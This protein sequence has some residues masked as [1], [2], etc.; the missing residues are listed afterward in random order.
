MGTVS[1]KPWRGRSACCMAG[2]KH[3]RI[4]RSAAG[5]TGSPATRTSHR[6]VDFG[7]SLVFCE[8]AGQSTF[9]HRLLKSTK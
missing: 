7:G 9:S 6:Q 3:T 2:I 1:T 8:H 5:D 4:V